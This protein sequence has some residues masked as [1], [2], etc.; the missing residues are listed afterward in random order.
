MRITAAANSSHY[1]ISNILGFNYGYGGNGVFAADNYLYFGAAFGK[2][3][4]LDTWKAMLAARYAAGNPVI[5]WYQPASESDATGLYAPII[6]QGGEY[7]ATCLELTAPLCEGD[8]VVSWAKSG[9]DVKTTF[10]GSEDEDW[11]LSGSP[12][13]GYVKAYIAASGV[14][15]NSALSDWLRKGSFKTDWIANTSS[16]YISASED[17]NICL[18]IKTN[19]GNTIEN[20]RSILAAHPL[21][22]WYRS[23]NY[24]ESSDIP[25]SLETHQRAVLVLDGTEPF[26]TNNTG[27]WTADYAQFYAANVSLPRNQSRAGDCTHGLYQEPAATDKSMAFVN[28]S[29][30]VY[31]RMPKANVG[32]TAESCKAYL[33]A[34][35]AAGTPVTIVYQ[36]ATPITYAHEAVELRAYEDSNNSYTISTQE[37]ATVSVTLKPMQAADTLDGFH[38]KDFMPN[39]ITIIRGRV[40]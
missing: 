12:V 27:G 10:D 25:V 37:N 21:T 17:G 3:Y 6:L 28:A 13:S 22:V 11:K 36:L 15:T 20:L 38:A 8:S 4:T 30:G 34:Q 26:V 7:R 23:T 33:A 5:F 29:G 16:E 39:T 35:Y 19:D 9:C 1:A 2:Q 40:Y 18:Q 24:T 32:E 31:L 14:I